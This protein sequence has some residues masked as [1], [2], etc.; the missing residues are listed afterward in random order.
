MK[1]ADFTA[2]QANKDKS[3]F[4]SS[5]GEVA[6]FL[7]SRG[8]I[9]TIDL[10]FPRDTVDKT[11][12]NLNSYTRDLVLN[13]NG[14]GDLLESTIKLMNAPE[15]DEDS[16]YEYGDDDIWND[17]LEI[18]YSGEEEEFEILDDK[19]AKSDKDE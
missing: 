1:E 15:E 19:K 9:D 4:A 12:G 13:E 6:A 8:F 17:D 7:E 10:E 18:D 11:I 14:L 3:D 5:F 2:Q 16:D